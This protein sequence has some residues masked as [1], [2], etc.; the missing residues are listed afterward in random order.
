LILVN[1]VGVPV[2]SGIWRAVGPDWCPGCF[3]DR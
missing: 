2:P 1:K 3:E